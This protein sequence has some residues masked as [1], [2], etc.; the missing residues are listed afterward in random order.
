MELADQDVEAPGAQGTS[1][2][3]GI[4]DLVK[5]GLGQMPRQNGCREGA[6]LRVLVNQ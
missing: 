3:G 1:K 4:V 2:A 6:V 5:P